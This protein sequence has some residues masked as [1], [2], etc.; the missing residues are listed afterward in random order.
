MNRI[1]NEWF[2]HRHI[3]RHEPSMKYKKWRPPGN[4]AA[5]PCLLLN[6]S[7]KTLLKTK[8]TAHFAVRSQQY[9]HYYIVRWKFNHISNL[10]QRFPASSFQEHTYHYRYVLSRA[11]PRRDDMWLHSGCWSMLMCIYIYIYRYIY[12]GSCVMCERQMVIYSMFNNNYD[13]IDVAGFIDMYIIYY[14]CVHCI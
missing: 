6:A 8:W 10:W 1:M 11:T 5:E 7:C 14:D 3:I 12:M 2:S 9:Y 4:C 13:S